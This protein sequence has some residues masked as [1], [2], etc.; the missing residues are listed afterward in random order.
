M[1]QTQVTE[2]EGKHPYLLSRFLLSQGSAVLKVQWTPH[3]DDLL[4][5]M[6]GEWNDRRDELAGAEDNKSYCCLAGGGSKPGPELR[7]VIHY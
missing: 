2:F 5:E 3:R 6:W 7:N 1:H 4:K